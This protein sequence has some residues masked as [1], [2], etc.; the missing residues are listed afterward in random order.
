MEGGIAVEMS[1]TV[2][3]SWGVCKDGYQITKMHKRPGL[4]DAE[5]PVAMLWDMG[6]RRLRSH[7]WYEPMRDR[8]ALFRTF[9]D[10]PTTP[11][12]VRSFANRFG[13]LGGKAAVQAVRMNPPPS[14]AQAASFVDAEPVAA[15]L[16][17]I[18]RMRQA[19]A[20]WDMVSSGDIEGLGQVIV[21]SLDGLQFHPKPEWFLTD[22]RRQKVEELNTDMHRFEGARLEAAEPIPFDYGDW[23]RPNFVRREGAALASAALLLLDRLAS[24]QLDVTTS[25][26]ADEKAGRMY[27]SHRPHSLGGA[28]W[29]QFAVSVSTGR[30]Y[31]VCKE[32]G[33][34]F[35]IPLRGARISREYCTN[36]CRSKAYRER[37]DRARALAAEGKAPKDIASE[38]DTTVSV[39]RKWLKSG[40]GN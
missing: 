3:F 39:V 40:K 24:D 22:W 30:R 18:L 28:L 9:A 32:C 26:E 14:A 15:W 20:I 34:W 5:K 37:Q 25:F 21:Q 19:V 16:N 7:S 13:M 17:A 38:L 10:T 23:L 4:P 36:A 35:E 6:A 12:G 11:E 2:E 27:L 33:E 1:G 31:R 29:L 8:P